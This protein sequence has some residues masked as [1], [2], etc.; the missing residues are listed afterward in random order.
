[1]VERGKA[2][3]DQHS[4]RESVTVKNTNRVLFEKQMK[5]SVSQLK[6]PLDNF[7]SDPRHLKN[8]I[9]QDSIIT[10]KNKLKVSKTADKKEQQNSSLSAALENV[11]RLN[12]EIKNQSNELKKSTSFA[13]LEQ[14]RKNKNLDSGSGSRR[15]LPGHQSVTSIDVSLRDTGAID[16]PKSAVELL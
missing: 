6:H 9:S 10:F 7:Q 13:L 15:Q 5:T 8:S 11:Q 2:P 16:E 1:M 3:H 12:E 14:Q 4:R